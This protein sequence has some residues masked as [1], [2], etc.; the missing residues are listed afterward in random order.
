MLLIYAVWRNFGNRKFD[1]V[2][3]PPLTEFVSHLGGGSGKLQ[4]ERVERWWKVDNA[5]KG[6]VPPRLNSWRGHCLESPLNIFTVPAKIWCDVDN[7]LIEWQISETHSVQFWSIL[8][9]DWVLEISSSIE[10]TCDKNSVV[11]DRSRKI[12]HCNEF[13]FLKI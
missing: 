3:R 5:G 1:A 4:N 7:S 2:T 12:G 10:R 6:V 13:A 8:C 9:T 11:G